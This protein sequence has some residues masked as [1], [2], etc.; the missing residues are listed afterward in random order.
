MGDIY[1]TVEVRSTFR[2]FEGYLRDLRDARFHE[3]S[4]KLRLFVNFC[5]KDDTF[6]VLTR[7][8][9]VRGGDPREWF[10]AS[11]AAGK[12]Q[13]LPDAPVDRLALMYRVLFEVKNQRID[14]RNL[15][16]TL[17][18]AATIEESQKGF[19]ARWLD[20]ME[21]AF[22]RFFAGVAPHLEGKEQVDFEEA[23]A[24]ALGAL[25]AIAAP[26][27]AAPGAAAPAE[28][29]KPAAGRKA[30]AAA[31]G[32]GLEALVKDLEKTA[33]AARLAAKQKA[34]LTADVK[35]LKI[36]LSKSAP[37]LQVVALVAESVER[38]GGKVSEIGAAIRDR[39]LT[40]A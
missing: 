33:K 39:A 32:A 27:A 14:L 6:R 7:H 11:A 3:F 31:D 16:S 19:A 12:M 17:F 38:A 20:A 28:A 37:N 40:R 15:L 13:P 8:L 25:D 26:G 36:E 4:T 30:G 5:E 23:A 22:R 29:G 34:D 18:T 24:E 1:S 9:H 35:I 2:T 21:G 10:T